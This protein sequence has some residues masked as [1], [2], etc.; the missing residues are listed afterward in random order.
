MFSTNGPASY[1]IVAHSGCS[2]AGV[3]EAYAISDG[4]SETAPQIEHCQRRDATSMLQN[5]LS[6]AAQWLQRTGSRSRRVR[7]R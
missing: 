5:G 1:S 6:T 2:S 4:S 7:G 3:L